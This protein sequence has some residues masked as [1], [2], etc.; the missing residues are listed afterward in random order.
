MPDFLLFN[1][2]YLAVPGVLTWVG[3]KRFKS[4][5]FIF[6]W[7]T[8]MHQL[9]WGDGTCTAA[10]SASSDVSALQQPLYRSSGCWASHI[11]RTQ[12]C[13]PYTMCYGYTDCAH[14]SYYRLPRTYFPFPWSFA[15]FVQ[16]RTVALWHSFITCFDV[17]SRN[18]TIYRN[19]SF[20]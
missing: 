16:R 5:K 18:Q 7:L 2:T 8:N 10:V 14:S 3:I 11:S 13:E 12:H 17:F 1:P 6:V 15:L 20:P 9:F 19:L 4:C